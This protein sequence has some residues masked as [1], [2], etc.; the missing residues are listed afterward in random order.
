M[1]RGADVA[2]G[3]PFVLARLGSV[4]LCHGDL[5]RGEAFLQQSLKLAR[6]IGDVHATAWTLFC[7]GGVAQTNGAFERSLALYEESLASTRRLNSRWLIQQTERFMSYTAVQ[8]G[9]FEQ[10]MALTEEAVALTREY[11]HLP[12]TCAAL[13]SLARVRRARGEWALAAAVYGESLEL[14]LQLDDSPEINRCILG[15]ADLAGAQGQ[16][17]RAAR[18]CGALAGWYDRV[19]NTMVPALRVDHERDLAAVRT[20]LGDDAF[21]AAWQVG[22]AMTI[23]QVV[24]E[25]LEALSLVRSG[26]EQSTAFVD[27]AEAGH[28]HATLERRSGSLHVPQPGRLHPASST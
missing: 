21:A 17:E 20:A 28:R 6:E 3:P 16:H 2:W 1:F 22:Q 26:S 4:A 15:L 23:E 19:Q 11:G 9:R 7:L 8:L 27:R 10:A 5:E 25:A 12:D 24:G 14:A 18:Y 13:R